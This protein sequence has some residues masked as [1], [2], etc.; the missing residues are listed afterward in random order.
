MAKSLQEVYAEEQKAYE[1]AVIIP[2]FMPP[3]GDYV[4]AF[5]GIVESVTKQNELLIVA[6]GTIA[7]GEQAGRQMILN[8]FGARNRGMLKQFV[9]LLIGTSKT[10]REDVEALKAKATEAPMLAITVERTTADNG[11]TYANAQ[12]NDLLAK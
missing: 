7:D 1:S 5:T 10:L 4:V 9:E 3:D 6:V 2:R 11:K 12:V 8:R